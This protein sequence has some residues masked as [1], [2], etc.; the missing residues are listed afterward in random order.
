MVVVLVKPAENVS[1]DRA[2][3][4]IVVRL[5]AWRSLER[6]RAYAEMSSMV[7]DRPRFRGAPR[8]S[9]NWVT[10]PLKE[11]SSITTAAYDQARQAL[12][13]SFVPSGTYEYL[14]VPPPVIIRFLNASS[15]G[16]FVNSHIK[17]NYRFRRVA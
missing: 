8:Q 11:S 2:G 9:E 12:R 6:H 16:R 5:A 7:Q 17:P 3:V 14:D 4:T 10:L 13:V 1:A 15:H